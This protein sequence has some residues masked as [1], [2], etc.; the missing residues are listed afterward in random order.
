MRVSACLYMAFKNFIGKKRTM[1]K[2]FAVYAMIIV[3]VLCLFSYRQSIDKQLNTIVSKSASA[4]FV[5]TDSRLDTSK[6]PM[7]NEIKIV[8][9]YDPNLN[10]DRISMTI[11]DSEKRLGVNDY[12]YN[13]ETDFSVGT[14]KET[15]AVPFKIDAYSPEGVVFSA[16]DLREFFEKNRDVKPVIEGEIFPGENGIV[17]S[18]YMLEKFGLEADAK[19]IGAEITLTDI[20]TGKVICGGLTLS[21]IIDSGLYYTE[22]N[23]FNAQIIVSDKSASEDYESPVYLYY[24]EDYAST[25]NLAL[26]VSSDQIRSRYSSLLEMYNAI[27][28]QQLIVRKV[29]GIILSALFLAMTVSVLTVL[30]FYYVQQKSYRQMVRAIGMRDADVF[31]CAFFEQVYCLVAAAVVGTGI[32]IVL[33]DLINAY[34]SAALSLSISIQAESIGLLL[35][36]STGVI[37][38]FSALVTAIS[39]LRLTREPISLSMTQ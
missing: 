36:S 6:Y 13:F 19:W 30:F 11:N 22:A 29:V 1:I 18:D 28:N 25:Y 21:G 35:L 26:A 15:Y 10:L 5:E 8:R 37:L 7:I 2:L 20:E 31:A 23:R 24:G 33:I 32:S 3:V 14:L 9:S 4:C 17:M 38:L 34:F 39:C 12:S 16:Q 27:E